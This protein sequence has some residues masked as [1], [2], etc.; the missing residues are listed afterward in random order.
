MFD[1]TYE[2]K[3]PC[4]YKKNKFVIYVCYAQR[5][6]RFYGLYTDFKKRFNLHLKPKSK[7]KV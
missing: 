1:D 6:H 4:F 3:I 5:G 2:V 7:Q